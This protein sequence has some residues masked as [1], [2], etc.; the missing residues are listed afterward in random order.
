MIGA[1]STVQPVPVEIGGLEA[2]AAPCPSSP[3]VLSEQDIAALL[4]QYPTAEE[5][6]RRFWGPR[7][8]NHRACEVYERAR[9]DGLLALGARF[10]QL[11]RHEEPELEGSPRAV[12]R[13]RR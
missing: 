2:F 3:P 13:G 10:N 12:R 1:C 7:D 5:R 11:A 6:E 9:A 4:A 8:Q